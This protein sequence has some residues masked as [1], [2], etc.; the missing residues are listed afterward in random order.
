MTRTSNYHGM[1]PLS[2]IFFPGP[3]L[4]EAGNHSCTNLVHFFQQTNGLHNHLQRR[5]RYGLLE[6]RWLVR[7]LS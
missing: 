6:G 5:L 4:K 3:T 7:R 1:G 2:M